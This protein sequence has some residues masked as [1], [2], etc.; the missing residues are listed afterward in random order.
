MPAVHSRAPAAP[1]RAPARP[2]GERR[3]Q[4]IDAAIVE[5]AARGYREVGTADIARRVGVSEP[6]VYRHFESKLAIY[7][8]A[9]DHSTRMIVEAWR[10]LVET[11]PTPLDALRAIGLWS[12]EQLRDGPPHLALRA[13]ALVEASE[14][15]ASRRLRDDFEESLALI[16]RLYEAARTAGLVPPTLDVRARAWAFMGLGALLDRTQL[17][18]LGAHLDADTMR[19]L[20]TSVMPEL[21]ARPPTSPA[22]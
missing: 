10:A 3:R 4:I 1:K 22:R 14:P 15:E 16:E 17:L 8:E 6:T 12:F 2:A 7:L 20:V 19:R 11:G 5:F 21:A 9:L 18:G 13:R